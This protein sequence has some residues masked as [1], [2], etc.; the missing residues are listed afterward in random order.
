MLALIE[1]L[2]IHYSFKK[3]NIQNS[4][5]AVNSHQTVLVLVQK[6][7]HARVYLGDACATLQV[8]LGRKSKPSIYMVRNFKPRNRYTILIL[9]I[10]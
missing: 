1:R 3:E 6:K 8:F 2:T 5:C 10:R 9:M 7:I 4:Q